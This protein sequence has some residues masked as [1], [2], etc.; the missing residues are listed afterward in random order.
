MEKQAKFW[1]DEGVLLTITAN[2][3]GQSGTVFASNGSPR[4]GDPTKN[5]PSV[6][7]TAEHYNRI[8][9]LLDHN[10]P[11][12]LSFDIKVNFDTT[13]TDSFNVIAEI[14]GT[15]KPNEVVMVGGHFDSW[16]MGTGATDNAA[17]SAV[18]MEVMRIL[19]SANL[20]M[21][22]TVRIA[23]WGGEEEG[24]L[25]SRAYVKEHFADPAT[26]NATR[27]LIRNPGL[28]GLRSGGISL[29]RTPLA[30][31]ASKSSACPFG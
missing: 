23:L 21:D 11:V 5:L 2:A 22:R 3:R 30:A 9:R 6:A 27:F 8:V 17:G 28:V 10:V 24:L 14:P 4:T 26:M 31:M 7:I 13:N 25:G 1:Q 16:H 18:A 19:K 29:T 20:K 12:K 15:T